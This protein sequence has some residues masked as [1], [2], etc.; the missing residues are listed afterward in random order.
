[1]V[2]ELYL[3]EYLP[4][5]YFEEQTFFIFVHRKYK[6]RERISKKYPLLLPEFTCQRFFLHFFGTT[7][8]ACWYYVVFKQDH[9]TY[10]WIDWFGRCRRRQRCHILSL[11]FLILEL[12]VVCNLFGNLCRANGMP[13]SSCSNSITIKMFTWSLCIWWIPATLSVS[14]CDYI[15]GEG[16]TVKASWQHKIMCVKQHH[17]M[18][19][20][21]C[22]FG[23]CQQVCQYFKLY[24]CICRYLQLNW[25]LYIWKNSW[26]VFISARG[27]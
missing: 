4:R 9:Y 8:K 17:N 10:S 24:R 23:G 7:N 15:F 26:G 21:F 11:Q 20:G 2:L 13:T 3:N 6:K 19:P 16:K 18:F 22:D 27:E 12:H 25:I 1:M 5:L 14:I